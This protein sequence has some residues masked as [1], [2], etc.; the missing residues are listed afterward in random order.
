VR[1]AAAA[2]QRQGNGNGNGNGNCRDHAVAERF[3]A[4]LEWELLAEETC[5]AR[6][7]AMRALMPFSR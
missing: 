7:M 1:R 5:A 3:F 4:T 2:R 6:A